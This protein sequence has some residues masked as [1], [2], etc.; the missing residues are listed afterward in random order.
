MLPASLCGHFF[1]VTKP[2]EASHL[3]VCLRDACHAPQSHVWVSSELSE[4]MLVFVLSDRSL[5]ANTIDFTA[6]LLYGDV[7]QDFPVGA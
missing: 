4:E 5:P 2:S 6:V 3:L 7:S 1:V